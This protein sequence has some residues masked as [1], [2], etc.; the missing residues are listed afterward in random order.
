MDMKMNELIG[1]QM[2]EWIGRWMARRMYACMDKQI[3]G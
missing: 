1:G 3:D 2:D